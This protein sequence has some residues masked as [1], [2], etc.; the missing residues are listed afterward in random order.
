[1]SSSSS[2]STHPS[3]QGDLFTRIETELFNVLKT[4]GFISNSGDWARNHQ[5]EHNDL[6]VGVLK[7]YEA[8]GVVLL[9]TIEQRSVVL[10]EDGN[11]ILKN[12]SPEVRIFNAIPQD[13]VNQ[14]EFDKQIKASLGDLTVKLGFAEAMKKKWIKIEKET[15]K[16]LRTV[17]SVE[18]DTRA[19]LEDLSC[20]N[21]SGVQALRRRKLVHDA[22][23]KTFSV[24][25][26]PKFTPNWRKPIADIT[27]EMLASGSWR[28]E[29]FKDYNFQAM[30]SL[31]AGGHLHPL[32][33]VRAEFREI[34]LE[35][36]FEEMFTSRYVESSFWNFD[37]LFQ[38]Q[39]HPARDAHDT[40]FLINPA[41]APENSVPRDY[42]ESVKQM[43]ETG[44]FGSVGYRYDWKEEEA[45]KN[46][47][48]T[49]TTA[50]SSRMLYQL[51]QDYK[52]T[53]VFTPKK[54]FSIDRVFRNETLDATHLAEFHQIE[55]LI[56]DRNITLPH[57]IG[58][59][60]QF[61]HRLGIYDIRFK[62]AYNPYTEP[63]MEIFGFH[64]ILQKWVELGNSG[65]FRPEML[66]P[67]GLPEDVRVIAWGLGMER[68][69]MIKY[70]IPNIRDIF[71]P[72]IDLDF[73]KKNPLALMEIRK[74]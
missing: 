38:P 10:T 39:Q 43:H 34:F 17:P 19:Q 36:G 45:R 63:S 71:G 56:A 74:D 69:T 26:G 49:H 27:P 41:L 25:R 53:G 35:L 59:I 72:R 33:K 54:Y 16:L 40:F 9:D 7:S 51:A 61:F 73:V 2:S 37:S 52:K 30:G 65:M 44:G 8:W 31:T 28:D 20:L 12:G 24:K 58:I 14:K 46:I 3:D 18:D 68:P 67:M 42:L 66:L 62:P 47:L 13:G 29:Q 15:G 21:E 6:L 1:M 64:P 32:M 60:S 23:F 22:V 4:E 48:R 55:G 70:K 50:I 11:E 5:W 57:L